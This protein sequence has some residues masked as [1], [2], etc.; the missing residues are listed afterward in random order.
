MSGTPFRLNMMPMTAAGHAAWALG[1]VYTDAGTVL[2]G[3]VTE[4]VGL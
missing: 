4:V 1:V 2:L 3:T